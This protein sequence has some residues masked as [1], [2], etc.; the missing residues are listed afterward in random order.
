[1]VEKNFE[2]VVIMLVGVVIL[3]LFSFKDACAENWRKVLCKLSL[4]RGSSIDRDK[5]RRLLL[6]YTGHGV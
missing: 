4:H 6:L 1:M 2:K 3:L 5:G